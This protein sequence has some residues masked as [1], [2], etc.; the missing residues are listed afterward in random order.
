M[1]PKKT[2]GK[3]CLLYQA[4]NLKSKQLTSGKN[5]E[6]IEANDNIFQPKISCNSIAIIYNKNKNCHM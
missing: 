4:N 1:S 5:Q 2:C 6:T 3:Q